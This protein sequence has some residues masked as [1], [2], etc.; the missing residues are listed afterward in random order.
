MLQV[1]R[2]LLGLYLKGNNI[3]DE[4]GIVLANSLYYNH[5]LQKLNISSNEIG[6]ATTTV[7]AKSLK[8]NTGLKELHVN[9]NVPIEESIGIIPIYDALEYNTTLQVLVHGRLIYRPYD[10]YQGNQQQL[11]QE[12]YNATIQRLIEYNDTLNFLTNLDLPR[13]IKQ[14]DLWSYSDR[15][16]R[17]NNDDDDNDD[18]N[19]TD[20]V[21]L[22]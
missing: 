6:E 10:L 17:T 11:L 4:G 16:N 14:I 20:D 22:Q 15:T 2:T 7:L 21:I 19:N 13:F 18:D 12:Q 9:N 5:T 3:I 8:Y 1:N